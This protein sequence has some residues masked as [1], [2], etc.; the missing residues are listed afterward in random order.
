M[1]QDD[2]RKRQPIVKDHLIDSGDLQI[3]KYSLINTTDLLYPQ[4]VSF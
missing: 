3:S 2:E 1:L 4:C